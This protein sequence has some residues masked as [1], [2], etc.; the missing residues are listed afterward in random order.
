M[1]IILRMNINELENMYGQLVPG[2]Q[3]LPRNRI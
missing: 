1:K 2:K 3:K